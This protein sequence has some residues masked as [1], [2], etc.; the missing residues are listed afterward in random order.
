VG[1]INRRL[2]EINF[3]FICIHSHGDGAVP[4]SGSQKLMERSKSKDKRLVELYDAG[5]A[6]TTDKEWPIAFENII[7]F[8]EKR[9]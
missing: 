1:E 9:R 8:M 3:P 6:M 5:H 4:I 2:D 7:N